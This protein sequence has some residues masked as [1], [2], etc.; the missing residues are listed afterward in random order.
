MADERFDIVF[1]GELVTGTDEATA[2][3]R[4]KQRFAL[5][6][7]ALAHLFQGRPVSVKRGVDAVAAARYRALFQEAG[8]LVR[9]DPVAA[10]AEVP[11]SDRQTRPPG[12]DRESDASRPTTLSLSTETGYLEELPD[13]PPPDLDLSY[14]S[15]ETSEDWSLEDCEPPPL[16]IPLPD[17]SHLSV[18]EDEV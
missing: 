4:L 18:V 6:D 8:A 9:I 16:P 5:T 13:H 14:L 17:I 12:A 3:A 1:C 2:K 7:D 10:A 15:L 11:V